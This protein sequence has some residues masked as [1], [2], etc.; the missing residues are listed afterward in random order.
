MTPTTPR[1]TP[2]TTDQNSRPTMAT[3]SAA[4]P[5]PFFGVGGR[6]RVSAVLRGG[7]IAAG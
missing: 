6:E 5:S 4:V 2:P 7:G 3:T 1:T